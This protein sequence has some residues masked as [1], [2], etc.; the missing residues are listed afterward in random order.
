MV[1][2]KCVRRLAHI[3]RAFSIS[4]VRV[5]GKQV[6]RSCGTGRS[7][8]ISTTWKA[9]CRTWKNEEPCIKQNFRHRAGHGILIE[10]LPDFKIS[11][12]V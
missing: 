8:V 1:L 11:R 6:R 9:C 7:Y 10:A 4:L 12:L 2:M 5:P 3:K